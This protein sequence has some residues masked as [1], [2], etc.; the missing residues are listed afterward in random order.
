MASTSGTAVSSYI[1]SLRGSE[2]L[3]FR[4]SGAD[5]APTTELGVMND[6]LT[7]WKEVRHVTMYSSSGRNIL[8]A[9]VSDS[10]A[11][12]PSLAPSFEGEKRRSGRLSEYEVEYDLGICGDW[13]CGFERLEASSGPSKKA[14]T[15]ISGALSLSHMP[16]VAEAPWPVKMVLFGTCGEAEKFARL[17]LFPDAMS[18]A[19]VTS[20]NEI[21]RAHV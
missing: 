17:E 16:L 2:T 14:D 21:G 5:R 6:E 19:S 9:A 7:H 13:R 10:Y 15:E 11:L 20:D 18:L 8:L 12:W 1:G 4:V 3:R